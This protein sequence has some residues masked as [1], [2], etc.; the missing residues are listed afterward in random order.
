MST[1]RFA[2]RAGA[3][4]VAAFMVLGATDLRADTTDEECAE[5]WAE[6][7]ASAT[8]TDTTA[9]VAFGNECSI[10]T[11]CD[12]EGFPTPASITRPLED[13]SELRNCL[14]TLT[15]GPCDGEEEPE[16]PTVAEICEENF[17]TSAASSVCEGTAFTETGDGK[18]FVDAQCTKTNSHVVRAVAILPPEN[19]ANLHFCQHGFLQGPCD[20][21]PPPLSEQC[22]D[23][24]EESP[25]N[26]A[27]D[28]NV[29][30]EKITEYGED[31]CKL[32]GS[33]KRGKMS[34]MS[35]VIGPPS[36]ISDLH[37]CNGQFNVGECTP[38][39]LEPTEKDQECVEGWEQSPAAESCS[40][41]DIYWDYWP[42][43]FDD[44]SCEIDVTCEKDDGTLNE[45]TAFHASLEQ[46]SKIIAC[47]GLIYRE[48]HLSTP[49]QCPTPWSPD[50]EPDP[51]TTEEC[52]EAWDA[53]PAG[54]ECSGTY[55]AAEGDV[56]R[57][58]TFC[59]R[60]PALRGS[61]SY[62]P[63]D[64][65]AGL[66]NC[67][68]LPSTECNEEDLEPSD[69][70]QD[71]IDAWEEA[72]ASQACEP[73]DIYREIWTTPDSQEWGWCVMHVQC[74]LAN[75]DMSEMHSYNNPLEEMSR[76]VNCNNGEIY[77]DSCPSWT[78]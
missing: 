39:D 26:V 50:P 25:A 15:V 16:D 73:S 34:M 13:I 52:R 9:E 10:E 31:Q 17:E 75:G 77:Y 68:G 62:L 63:L 65:V 36:D 40:I 66:I 35:E 20:P 70:D 6:S 55:V 43:Q 24:W 21:P 23:A 49:G 11:T 61:K 72:E 30:P 69:G 44:G 58:S 51:P 45:Q 2:A 8:C 1:G 60:P 71:C 4:V 29:Y 3:L 46:I 33:C 37:A 18:C 38:E 22:A 12:K 5:A 42:G 41:T 14:A 54:E 32:Q 19:A 76:F 53:S 64:D 47:D 74:P 56:C 48:E 7:E 27:E 28:C 59:P 78:E 67:A 57:I